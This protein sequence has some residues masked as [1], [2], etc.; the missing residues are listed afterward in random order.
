MRD[1]VAAAWQI[2]WQF[3]F[4]F[5]VTTLIGVHCGGK[6]AE[7]PALLSVCFMLSSGLRTPFV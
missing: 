2:D 5:R 3:H 1:G 4:H 7:E 6:Y